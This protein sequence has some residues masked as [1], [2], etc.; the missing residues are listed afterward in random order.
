MASVRRA[1]QGMWY[2]IDA[3]IVSKSAEGLARGMTVIET[4]FEATDI[5]VSEKRTEI[6]LLRTPDQTTL[7]PQLVIQIA[8]QR[9][10]RTAQFLY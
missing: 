5:T 10:I 2:I 4:V 8:G 7:A 3:G 1:V 6:I 9:Y